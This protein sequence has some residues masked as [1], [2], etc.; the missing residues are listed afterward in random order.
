[1][2]KF[3]LLLA[4]LAL[5]FVGTGTASAD[6]QL[7]LENE[8]TT[9]A[10]LVEGD[11]IIYGNSTPRYMYIEDVTASGQNVR[12]T[13][14]SP[15]DE[16]FETENAYKSFVVTVAMNDEGLWTIK[17]ANG[18]YV[19]V[20]AANTA[21]VTS[22]DAEGF[23]TSDGANGILFKST[24]GVWV[25]CNNSSNVFWGYNG[26]GD[27][28][29]LRLCTFSVNEIV[30][31]GWTLLNYYMTQNFPDGADNI[32]VAGTA[33]GE[34]PE[35]YVQAFLD[36]YDTAAELLMDDSQDASVYED[37]K[38]ALEAAYAA[39]QE[40]RNNVKEG[41]YRFRV[42]PS[43]PAGSYK[44]GA[45]AYATTGGYAAWIGD[46]SYTVPEELSVE[47]AYYIWKFEADA[48]VENGYKIY[49][50]GLKKYL[51]S[52]SGYSK[53]IPLAD[54]GT[55]Y[56]AATHATYGNAFSL[57]N[58]SNA[59]HGQVSGHSVVYWTVSAAAS[60]WIFEEVDE[61]SLESI[62]DQIDQNNRNNELE[63]LYATAD[64]ALASGWAYSSDATEDGNFDVDGLVVPTTTTST[65]TDPDTGE[66]VTST[67]VSCDKIWTNAQETSEG[68]LMNVL[69]GD[70]TSFF[71]TAWSAASG[72][73]THNLCF[74]VQKQISV[75][76]VKYAKRHND[77]N[78]YPVNV[79]VYATNTQPA[80]WED[81]IGGDI[82]VDKGII[83]FSYPYSFPSE[84][85]GA[86]AT[87]NMVGIASCN[88]DE[89]YRY[90]RLDVV[91]TANNKTSSYGEKY[92]NLSE[93]RV[94]EGQLDESKSE[95][96]I[97]DDE[98]ITN[99]ENALAEAEEALANG[100]ATQENIDNL[101]AAYDAYMNAFPDQT[102]LKEEIA[103]AKELEAAAED[104]EGDEIGY[105]EAGSAS[106]L[107]DAIENIESQMKDLMS[108]DEIESL[109]S[110]LAD[111]VAALN[112]KL[113]L[114]TV[115]TYYRIVC[116][117]SQTTQTDKSVYAL[118]NGAPLGY[119]LEDQDPNIEALG[120]LDAIWK[121]VE[122]GDGI[123]LQNM[124]TGSYFGHTDATSN[125]TVITMSEEAVPVE[126]VFAK[127][128]GQVGFKQNDTPMYTHCS[129]GGDLV[130]WSTIGA[131]GNGAF[132][133]VEVDA[134]AWESMTSHFVEF[135]DSNP[136]FVTFPFEVASADYPI[137][138]VVGVLSSDAGVTLECEVTEDAVEA[139]S[140]FIIACE[141]ATNCNFYTSAMTLDELTFA[142]AASNANGAYGVLA[143]D[144]VAG[145]FIL[146]EGALT[147]S[148]EGAV[149]YNTGY[150]VYSEL[151][152]LSNAGD[153]SIPVDEEVLT[154]VKVVLNDPKN[155][156]TKIYNLQGVRVQKL[157]KG[158]NIVNGQKVLV[159]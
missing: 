17:L 154:G 44:E 118:G 139:G 39:C 27:L 140:P 124:F 84:V 30:M 10:D 72:Y 114:P 41:Y 7:T 128:A 78:A 147:E 98:I 97:I 107:L 52:V 49:N 133:F 87:D 14:S 33:P 62:A 91:S 93:F 131:N 112:A 70:F 81:S 35:S 32:F 151:E 102:E 153:L 77:L 144:T 15:F 19:P 63:E 58:G 42:Y 103:A 145:A 142:T 123:G 47:D 150:V 23:E 8:I 45:Y 127:A 75:L 3:Q 134:S 65:S 71:H 90:F 135:G 155:G 50:Y 25:N 158:V 100:T 86:R 5:L 20:L 31:E 1:M 104:A 54:E 101:Q 80:T 110:Q 43:Q 24:S 108:K 88:L 141:D 67:T 61:S 117:S 105:F 51:G 73:T 130:T 159:K 56:V 2:R 12:F 69:D 38:A 148:E 95:N 136:H 9:T 37:A 137:Y 21:I 64:A 125:S 157:Q 119:D 18:E 106:E 120:R 138:K 126:I 116:Q 92:F 53:Q 89:G 115:G 99:L 96:T 82:W 83:E 74:D 66:E 13:T 55:T 57:A 94:Y 113:V 4:T 68:A 46:Q 40:N 11:Y 34:V 36:A 26:N 28:S 48:E 156:T 132:N 111:A 79:H 149:K 85:E 146:S 16:V 60:A 152:T 29:Q 122:V 59:L 6:Y 22:T 129:G 143:A 109:R 76:T 121:V